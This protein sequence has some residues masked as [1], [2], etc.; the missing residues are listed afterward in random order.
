MDTNMEFKNNYCD[1]KRVI[2]TNLYELPTLPTWA[3]SDLF[4]ST[5]LVL[6]LGILIFTTSGCSGSESQQSVFACLVL[7]SMVCFGSRVI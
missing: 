3:C 2:N 1:I 6:I 7:W 4:Q 5:A